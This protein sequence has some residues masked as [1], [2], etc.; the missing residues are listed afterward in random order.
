MFVDIN[1]YGQ[2][3][4]LTK[5]LKTNIKIPFASIQH[6]YINTN[7]FDMSGPRKLKAVPYLVWNKKIENYFQSKKDYNV[8]AI[9]APFIYIKNIKKKNPKGSMLM[10]IHSENMLKQEIASKLLLRKIK[11]HYPAPHKISLFYKDYNTKNIN[12]YKNQ[13]FKVITFGS[14]NNTN[15]LSKLYKT[16]NEIECFI[17]DYV[18]SPFFYALYLK[19]KTKLIQNQ[20]KYNT[21]LNTKKFYNKFMSFKER[22][23]QEFFKKFYNSKF[24]P[25][26]VG[27]KI[28]YEELGVEYLKTK[29]ELFK[30]LGYDYLWKK[31]VAKISLKIRLKS[32]YYK[33][34]LE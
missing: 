4:I 15:H 6:G 9:G 17:T 3:S 34:F 1:W 19:T 29:S 26:K 23:R 11:K 12:Y 28:A 32:L 33:S 16:L 5:Y 21:D 7:D 31:I 20:Y 13:G 30:L 27:Y 10:L 24:I 2:L 14:R 18:G 22:E 25:Q 8:K